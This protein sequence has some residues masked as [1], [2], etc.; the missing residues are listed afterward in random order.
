METVGNDYWVILCTLSTAIERNDEDYINDK[1]HPLILDK[2][3]K[4]VKTNIKVLFAFCQFY[5]DIH[6]EKGKNDNVFFNITEY[7][8]IRTIEL[9]KKLK[10][11]VFFDF[12][13]IIF[14]RKMWK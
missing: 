9:N 14:Q 3:L 1:F 7:I 4:V 12:V 6:F 8:L 13:L 5:K 2:I 10:L 11:T